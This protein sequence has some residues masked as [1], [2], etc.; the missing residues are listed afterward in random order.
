MS[1]QTAEMAVPAPSTRVRWWQGLREDPARMAAVRDCWRALWLSRL[2]VWVASVGTILSFG[3]GPLRG[4][5]NPPGLTRGFGWLGD[6]LAAPAARWDASWYLV[7]AHYGYRPDFGSF[8][9][10][11]T[12]FF[13]L[14]PLGI[15]GLSD[16]GLPPVLAGVLISVLALGLALYG[17]HRLTTL[18]LAAA[19]PDVGAVARLAVLLSALAPMAF[20]FS[21]IYTESLYLALS[22]G[23][24]WCARHGRWAGVGVLGALAAATRSTGVVLVLPALLL[25][26][27][28]PREDRPPDSAHTHLPW[29][30][31]YRLR[32]D[33][34]WLVL[35]PLGAGLYMAYLAL[36][37]GDALLPFHAQDVWDRHF[38]GPF[39]GVWDGLIAGFDGVRQLLSGQ[40]H[41]IYFVPTQGSPMVAAGHNALLL[42]FLLLALPALVGVFRRLPVAYGVYVVIA[43]ALPLSTPVASQPLMSLPRFEVVLFP[44]TIWAALWL[45]PRRRLA[46][47]T[48]VV[49]ALLMAL[50]VAQFSTWHWVA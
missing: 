31:R 14:Y 27:Y 28:G 48:L 33:F 17:I 26:L 9:A 47:A 6:L 10:S 36:S 46:I 49:S 3:W 15:S 19:R 50:F 22:V 43:L 11:R 34:L 30:P 5:F 21:A 37:G 2:L 25:Y 44:L 7:I 4:A 41:H 40:S 24:F 16:L 38:A 23:L 29:R 1:S 12:A 20:F 35:V 8:T 32:R 13:P 18:E 42:G 39:V 45:A